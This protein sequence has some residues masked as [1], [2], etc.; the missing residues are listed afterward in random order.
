MEFNYVINYAWCPLWVFN[1]FLCFSSFLCSKVV[2]A[3]IY[4]N[5]GECDL[6]WNIWRMTINS[7]WLMHRRINMSHSWNASLELARRAFI[8]HREHTY[9]YPVSPGEP[10]KGFKQQVM[11]LNFIWEITLLI[12]HENGI[13][14]RRYERINSSTLYL[15]LQLGKQASS[16]TPQSFIPHIS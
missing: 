12:W 11:G 15:V 2:L 4:R 3:D 6:V 14:G 9:L 5:T 8:Y 13:R 1:I 10:W 16:L 7:G